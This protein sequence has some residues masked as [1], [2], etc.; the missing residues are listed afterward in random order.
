M[1]SWEAFFVGLLILVALLVVFKAPR[2][3]S[4]GTSSGD[5]AHDRWIYQPWQDGDSTSHH[6]Q[7][8]GHAQRHDTH[9]SSQGGGHDA[10]GSH[11]GGGSFDGGS[12]DGGSSDGGSGGSHH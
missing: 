1:S 4:S 9:D 3:R 2:V 7:E 5:S 12:S 11:H 6:Q 8:H 10:G